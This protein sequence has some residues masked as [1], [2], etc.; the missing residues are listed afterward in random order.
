LTIPVGV[1]DNVL[2]GDVRE[3]VLPG[4]RRADAWV[5]RQFV[6][7]ASAGRV[8][9][10]KLADMQHVASELVTNALQHGLPRPISVIV[11]LRRR[12]AALSVASQSATDA[13]IPHASEWGLIGLNGRTGR[14]LAIVNGLSDSVEVERWGESLSIT[15]HFKWR[16][17]ARGGDAAETPVATV[18][19]SDSPP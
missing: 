7:R 10:S 3:L 5:S 1:C 2:I 11:H 18:T 6:H 8:P 15:A 19:G 12:R 9:A 14:G 17:D 16:S 4:D 13:V